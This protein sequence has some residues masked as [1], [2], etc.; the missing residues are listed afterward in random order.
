MPEQNDKAKSLRRQVTRKL[1]RKL[2]V[3]EIKKGLSTGAMSRLLQFFSPG[4]KV[5]PHSPS[6]RSGRI[7]V[8]GT[9]AKAK[10]IFAE[11]DLDNNHLLTYNEARA[12]LKKLAQDAGITVPLTAGQ[13][14]ALFTV[15]DEC[16]D[17]LV[18]M[19]EFLRFYA[20][21]TQWTREEGRLEKEA[22]A[23]AERARPWD[24]S[25]T[26]MIH[27]IAKHNTGDAVGTDAPDAGTASGLLRAA[28]M[29]GLPTAYTNDETHN[30]MGAFLLASCGHK[31]GV[32]GVGAH[33]P[34]DKEAM[35]AM[36]ERHRQGRVDMGVL[37]QLQPP[38]A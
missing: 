20:K 9:E 36:I 10:A 30:L 27:E 5:G 13:L 26:N 25:E 4:P 31:D 17:N 29:S 19:D 23:A 21:F 37:E 8:Q 16:P 3:K 33:G 24:A 11:F 35:E 7:L 12:A 6:N 38:F 32:H 14:D 34:N 1:Q 2:S 28:R 22:A 18:S 15:M